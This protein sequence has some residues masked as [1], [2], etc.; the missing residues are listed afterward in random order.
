[1]KRRISWALGALAYTAPPA[2]AYFAQ[3]SLYEGAK[4][5]GEYIC[6]LPMLVS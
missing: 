5:R 1:M 2:W 4:E 3:A 6:G